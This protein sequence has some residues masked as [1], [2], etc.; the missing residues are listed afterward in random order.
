MLQYQSENAM[1]NDRMQAERQQ[2]LIEFYSILDRLEARIGGARKLADCGGRMTWPHRGVYFF[3]EPGELRTDSA[4]GPR[5]VR[6]GTHAIHSGSGTKLW[7]RLSQHRGQASTGGGNHRGSIFRLIVGAAL[8]RRDG[9]SFPTWGA[10]NTADREIR[11][12]ER[13]LECEVSQVIG[14]MPFLWLTVPDD[15]GPDS[16]R[17]FI[18]R[19]AIALLSNYKRTALDPPSPHWLGHHSDRVRVR[20]SGLW[21]QNHVDE[22]HDPAFLRTL[23]RLVSATA[24]VA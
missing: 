3:R 12:G 14:R 11:F 23:D 1:P 8:I 19:Y 17:G 9:H 22:R 7:T 24:D 10:G 2:D 13:A 16:L 20:N 5:I 6:V 4:A 15:A 21:D 18:E